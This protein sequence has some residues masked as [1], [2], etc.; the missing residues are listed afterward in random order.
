[1]SSG[2]NSPASGKTSPVGPRKTDV[3]DIAEDVINEARVAL[4]K[5]KMTEGP[6]FRQVAEVLGDVGKKA[7]NEAMTPAGVAPRSEKD[8]PRTPPRKVTP[9]NSPPNL[10]P[11]QLS[12]SSPPAPVAVPNSNRPRVLQR[13]GTNAQAPAAV[14]TPPV[15]LTPPSPNPLPPTVEPVPKVDAPALPVSVKT[16]SV[17]AVDPIVSSGLNGVLLSNSFTLSDAKAAYEKGLTDGRSSPVHTTPPM[18]ASG[19]LP[20]P[21]KS[22]T[23][24]GKVDTIKPTGYVFDSDKDLPAPFRIISSQMEMIQ[25]RVDEFKPIIETLVYWEALKI[26]A[27]FGT[28]VVVSYILGRWRLSF[29]WVVIV[30]V[31]VSGAYRRNLGRLRNKVRAQLSREQAMKRIEQSSETLEWMNLF[32]QKF[33]LIYEPVLSDTVIGIVNEILDANKPGFLD[34]L[35]LAKFTLGSAAPRMEGVTSYTAMENDV[36]R[37]DWDLAF[38]PLDNPQI[39]ASA[40]FRNSNIELVAKIGKGVA[41]IPIPVLV[42]EMELTGRLRIELKLMTAFPHVKRFEASFMVKPHIGFILR[43]LKGLDMMDLPGLNNFINDIIDSQL[44]AIMVEPNRITI[45]VEDLLNSLDESSSIPAGILRVRISEG[46]G[47]KNVQTIGLSDPYACILLGGN[48]VMTARTKTIPQTLDPLWN[49]T[50]YIVIPRSILDSTEGEGD[51]VRIQVLDWNNLGKDRSIGYTREVQLRRWLRI[52]DDAPV[53]GADGSKGAAAPPKAADATVVVPKKLKMFSMPALDAEER[54]ELMNLWGSPYIDLSDV[55]LKLYDGDDK[56]HRGKTKGEVRMEMSWHP[57]P[58][59]PLVFTN[60]PKDVVSGVVQLSI[61][62]AKDLGSQR[63][64]SYVQV[65]ADNSDVFQ[66]PNKKGTATPVW[67]AKLSLFTL[68]V[69]KLALRLDLKDAAGPIL[70]SLTLNV[71]NDMKRLQEHPED[72]WF[73]MTGSG[74]RI[75]LSLKFTPVPIDAKGGKSKLATKEPIGIVRFKIKEARGLLNVEQLGNKSDPYAKVQLGSRSIGQTHVKDNT[76]NPT[77][78]EIFYGIC[79]SRR[80]QLNIELW[81]YNRMTKDRSLG[82]VDFKLIDLIKFPEINPTATSASLASIPAAPS[83]QV[84]STHGP[85]PTTNGEQPNHTTPVTTVTTTTHSDGSTT[86]ITAALPPSAPSVKKIDRKMERFKADGLEITSDSALE[87]DVWAPVYLRKATG[88]VNAVGAGA[89]A[90]GG[91]VVNVVGASGSAVIG[92]GGSV[93]GG[94]GSV[95]GSAGRSLGGAANK[96]IGGRKRPVVVQD[97]NQNV[98]A[99]VTAAENGLAPAE[100]S[101][102]SSGSRHSGDAYAYDYDGGEEKVKQKGHVHFEVVYYPTS[103]GNSVQAGDREAL[104]AYEER[105]FEINQGETEDAQRLRRAAWK[106]EVEEERAAWQE[107][108]KLRA[109]AEAHAAKI[110]ERHSV[111]ILRLKLLHANDI[112]RSSPYVE[113]VLNDEEVAFSTRAHPKTSA[114]IFEEAC[115]IFI[116]DLTTTA[117]TMRLKDA[118]GEKAKKTEK[119]PIICSWTGNAVDIIGREDYWLMMADFIPNPISG[120]IVGVAGQMMIDAGFVPVNVELDEAERSNTMGMLYVDILSATDL[121]S[122]DSN[123]FS[124]PYALVVLNDQKVHKTKI[125]K[126]TLNPVFDESVQVAI[127]SRLRSTF[128]VRIYD[129]NVTG[130][131]LLGV[132]DVDLSKLTPGQVLEKAFT[133][134]QAV[135]GSVKLRLYFDPQLVQVDSKKERT[136]GGQEKGTFAK[137]GRGLLSEVTGVGKKLTHEVTSVGGLRAD[138]A[139]SQSQIDPNMLKN[140]AQKREIEKGVAAQA[141]AAAEKATENGGDDATAHSSSSNSPKTSPKPSRLGNVLNAVG[142]KDGF[143]SIKRQSSTASIKDGGSTTHSDTTVEWGGLSVPKDSDTA[144]RPGSIASVETHDHGLLL[145]LTIVE[146]KDLNALDA[147]GTSDPFVKILSVDHKGKEKSHGKTAVIKKTLTPKWTNET[148]D[149][150]IPPSSL[151]LVLKDHN[152]FSGDG[153]LGEVDIDAMSFVHEHGEAFDLWLPVVK[154]SGSLH[155]TGKFSQSESSKAKKNLFRNLLGAS[156]ESINKA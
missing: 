42:S 87:A 54:E 99:P 81:D 7:M 61:H 68:D 112:R 135:S 100:P 145:H 89:M 47:L 56:E 37:M 148:F 39:E 25:Q 41:S 66:T 63:Y 154:G 38:V 76:L 141:E 134:S 49:E 79:Y 149:I 124:D 51:Q 17:V 31:F 105:P 21:P 106:K 77:W 64:T 75:R 93:I 86:S 57:V 96:L 132:V 48:R 27:Y 143:G 139:A 123:G 32:L 126:K 35:K 146:A 117:I 34:D 40:D 8:G 144:S 43:P 16:T 102:I 5:N 59:P 62:Q 15:T 78:N 108:E 23:A 85:T 6:T 137:F 70:G 73:R 80:E 142:I 114:P 36:V 95:V 13:G 131:A 152:T 83:V 88:V 92:V 129:Y 24:G 55:W 30:I 84:E 18:T 138:T 94:V 65:F 74:A 140:L 69:K 22:L 155:I 20:P 12:S 101:R 97:N 125:H 133:L 98:I 72:D 11:Q 4:E 53:D 1:M 103:A 119:D 136:Q 52:L 150:A 29:G 10:P 82:G 115:D 67:D 116:K 111:G 14:P 147:G 110:I 122:H 127:P 26:A 33:W 90:V 156:R 113:V 44:T 28:G 109:E 45:D 71:P 9:P 118:L 2:K 153:D 91:G 58:E 60:S 130:D 121:H 46:R 151:K 120:A 50:L 19:S 3:T 107:K 104:T 128:Q